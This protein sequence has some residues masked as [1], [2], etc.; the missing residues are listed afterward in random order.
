M[1]F[2]M[3]YEVQ[4]AKPWPADHER[5]LYP[6]NRRAGESGR[7]AG[8]RD[9]VAG[10]AQCDAGILLQL[11][12]GSVA[13]RSGAE[14]KAY[15]RRPFRRHRPPPRQHHPLRVAARTA[16]LDIMSDGRLDVGLAVSGGKEWA[17]FGADPGPR[18]RSTRRCSRCCR[19]CGRRTRSNG[20]APHI[21]VPRRQITPHPVQRPH[22]PLWQTAGSPKSF[23]MAG[24]RGV[25]LLALTIL[26]P[27]SAMDAMLR[28]YEAGLAECETPVGHF[29]QPPEG[30]VHLRARRRIRAPR[31]S[32]TARRS[33]RCGTCFRDRKASRCRSAPIRAVPLRGA[34]Q[35]AELGPSTSSTS[36]ARTAATPRC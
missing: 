6:R 1:K 12:A 20:R 16:T 17:S 27:V 22:P 29:T 23:R 9:L 5:R 11:R 2:D 34:S 26:S 7:P 8:L 3:F 33:R 4:S 35:L 25:G 30:G 19:G 36:S 13:R 21:T 31:R 32:R 10:R 18:P 15:P 24:R 14:H 28:E